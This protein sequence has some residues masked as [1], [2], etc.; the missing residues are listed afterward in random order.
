MLLILFVLD[1]A[2]LLHSDRRH[3]CSEVL[4]AAIKQTLGLLYLQNGP[5]QGNALLPLIFNFALEYAIRKVQV[6]W[7]ELKCNESYQLLFYADDVNLLHKNI[8]IL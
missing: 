6:N 1:W 4:T 2:S 5:K 7:K 3:V 8:Y